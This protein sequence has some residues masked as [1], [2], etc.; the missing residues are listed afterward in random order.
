MDVFNFIRILA[1]G[2][3]KTEAIFYQGGLN[4]WALRR[5]V[6]GGVG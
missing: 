1:V 3:Q 2:K 4:A 6:A 5:L